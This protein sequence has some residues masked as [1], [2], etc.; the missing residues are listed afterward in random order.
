[1]QWAKQEPQ[2]AVWTHRALQEKKCMKTLPNKLLFARWPRDD[3]HMKN[4]DFFKV[5]NGPFKM[6]SIRSTKDEHNDALVEHIV[7]GLNAEDLKN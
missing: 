7:R 1:M 3:F 2:K 5:F 4:P 6:C